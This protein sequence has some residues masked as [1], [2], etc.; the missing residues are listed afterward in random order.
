MSSV[1]FD[2]YDLAPMAKEHTES[3]EQTFA[4]L[5]AIVDNLVAN[6]TPAER[7]VIGGFSMGGGMALQFAFRTKHRL[8]NVFA[9]SSFANHDSAIYS[10]IQ[11]EQSERL[12]SI[13][14][15]H[16]A[17]GSLGFILF[18]IVSLSAA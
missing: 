2:R 11:K 9:L 15:R 3:I 12:P 13:F 10:M 18:T 5:E 1:W 8:R 6:G 16:G 14:M 7:I 17:Q 4:Q